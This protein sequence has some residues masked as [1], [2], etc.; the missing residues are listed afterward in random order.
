MHDFYN[1]NA[2]LV[3]ALHRYYTMLGHAKCDANPEG[4]GMFHSQL[5]A[6]GVV[7]GLH[8]QVPLY[9]PLAAERRLCVFAVSSRVGFEGE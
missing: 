1:D 5:N 4:K 7:P 9:C 6:K 3:K 2:S 8:L